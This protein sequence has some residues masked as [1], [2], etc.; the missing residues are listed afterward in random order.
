MT[1][2]LKPPRRQLLG[3][4]LGASLLSGT[5]PGAVPVACAAAPAG[6]RLALVIGNARYAVP[7]NALVNPANDARLVGDALRRRGFDTTVL[8]D[9]TTTQMANAVDEFATRASGADMAMVYFAG[10]AVALDD[11]N[12]LFGVELGIPLNDVRISTAQQYALSIKRVSLALRRANIRARLMVLDACRTALT[13]GQP[14]VGLTRAVPA[15][16]ELIAFSTQP[17][18]TAE[19]GFGR[20]GPRHSPY[21]FYFAQTLDTLPS[22]APVENFFKQL[23]SDVQIA[24]AYRQVPHYASSLVGTVT[25][26]SLVDGQSPAVPGGSISSKPGQAGR[27]PAPAPAL[28]RDLIRD[29]MSAWEYEI[30]HGAE[31][32]DTPR[33]E[34]LRARAKAGDVVAMTTLGLVMENG[35]HVKMDVKEAAG[36]YR[37][38]ADRDFAPAQ[39][40]LG[41]LVAVGKGVPKDFTLAERLLRAAADAGHRRAALDLIDLRARMGEPIDPNQLLKAM[42]D[43][44]GGAGGPQLPGMRNLPGMPSFPG[45]PNAPTQ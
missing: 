32:L 16:G 11:V 6:R 21:A 22:S 10:H 38:A 15:G 3:A 12:Y 30:E 23:T 5:W 45:L 40:Y 1:R 34:S 2:P 9:L 29:R 19:D 8:T 14:G 44:M 25:L 31:Y 17:G 43:A 18:A 28:G 33:L 26:A 27:G 42:K 13:R 35:K 41:E 24:T 20:E 37:R 39:T 7:G 4:L 36:W